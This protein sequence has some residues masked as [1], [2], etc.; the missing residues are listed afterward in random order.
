MRIFLSGFFVELNFEQLSQ[1]LFV[2]KINR[3]ARIPEKN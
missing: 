1:S 3:H 2:M